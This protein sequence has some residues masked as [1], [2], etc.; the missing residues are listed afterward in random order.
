MSDST[1]CLKMEIEWPNL[2]ENLED[3]HKEVEKWYP[4]L[5]AGEVPGSDYLGWINWPLADN[6]N[7]VRKINTIASEIREEA[8]FFVSTGI[9]GSYLGAR[10]VIEALKEKEVILGDSPE[11]LWAGHNISGSYH[12]YLLD[13]INSGSTYV[14]VISKSGT[15][16]ETAIA[17]RL[18]HKF[19]TGKYSAE[20]L[21]KRIVV[22]T[23]RD[24]GALI[25][26]AR[27]EG[28][29]NLEI[30]DDIGGRF[31]VFTAVGLLPAA[32]AGID[33]QQL[34]DGARAMATRLTAEPRLAGEAIHYAAARN[35]FYR[36]GG[37]VELLASFYPRL[38]RLGGWWQQL[39]G[40]SEGKEGKGLFPAAVDFSTDLH[41]LGQYIQEGPRDLLETFITLDEEPETI[42]VPE[43]KNSSDG[44]NYLAGKELAEI[45]RQAMLGTR[46]AHTAGGVPTIS[47]KIDQ[48]NE[49]YLGG[50]L[51]FF[52]FSCALSGLTL[53]VN[54][55][56]QPG[57]EAYK[58]NMYKRLGK[59]GIS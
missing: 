16:T 30:P 39:F 6:K 41:S 40:E 17:F 12:R 25:E 26:A 15:T 44:L 5:L 31:S 59:P 47:F 42:E 48:L 53:G 22:T 23:S 28:Y 18:L 36:S 49:Y 38:S 7:L 9:G 35:A 32:V 45:N 27:E 10:A 50:L 13:K 52:Q 37:R 4:K 34:L 11:I 19:L 29:R 14:N 51:Y 21:A 33:I 55:F 24:R 43:N 58:T 20:E 46:S 3:V 1:T 56:N 54:P 8:D 2:P 57:V